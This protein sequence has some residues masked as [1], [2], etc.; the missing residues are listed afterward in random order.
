MVV[1]NLQPLQ[2]RHIYLRAS[3]ELYYGYIERQ[4]LLETVSDVGDL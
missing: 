4:R 3:T 1:L 2:V